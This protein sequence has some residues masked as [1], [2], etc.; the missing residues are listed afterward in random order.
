MPIIRLPDPRPNEPVITLTLVR[1]SQ[2]PTLPR[3][4]SPMTM[5]G[6]RKP[7]RPPTKRPTDPINGTPIAMMSGSKPPETQSVNGT[8]AASNSA[9]ASP[10]PRSSSPQV[11]SDP[12]SA[13]GDALSFET[14]FAT[15]DAPGQY[16]FPARHS[17]VQL[18]RSR[19]NLHASVAGKP[20]P[21]YMLGESV[22]A[23]ATP[24]V[25][26]K[27]HA[28]NDELTSGAGHAFL[29]VTP[30]DASRHRE[31][32]ADAA[33]EARKRKASNDTYPQPPPKA[34]KVIPDSPTDG[35]A[36]HIESR[37]PVVTP[38]IEALVAP[39][40]SPS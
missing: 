37:P 30:D 18:P 5:S 39:T 25:I 33:S 4:P 22:D 6:K 14:P 20:E 9:M 27:E 29:A 21:E 1:W 19:S 16:V 12:A 35:N 10:S 38:R 36:V 2:N 13:T 26:A 31:L 24:N 8:A 23:G 11:S 32:P 15:R 28:Q 34:A 3:P 7:G 40:S 17:P